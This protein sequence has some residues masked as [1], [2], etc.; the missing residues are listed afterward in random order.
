M[1]TTNI[2]RRSFVLATIAAA[3]FFAAG[4]AHADGNEPMLKIVGEL[5]Y[6]QR[7]ALPDDAIAIVEL[8]PDDAPDGASVT[9]ESRIRLDG[10]Q[11]PVAFVLEVPRAHLDPAKHYLLR[12]G[13]LVEQ[14]MRWLSDPMPVDVAAASIDVGTVRLSPFEVEPP[15]AAVDGQQALSGEWRIVRVGEHTLGADAN[16]TIDFEADGGFSGRLCN[17]YRGSYTLDG[18]AIAFGRTAATLMACPE[19]QGSQERAL[20]SA[21]ESA[22]RFHVAEDGTLALIGADGRTLMTARR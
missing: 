14:Q 6:L 22:T 8:K 2:A 10:R 5:A 15:E 3:G 4:P 16:A 9:A 1:P 7:I 13:I 11:V 21:F 19:P 18:E 20:F 12:G 17:A